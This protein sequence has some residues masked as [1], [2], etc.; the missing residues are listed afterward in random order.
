MFSLQK[1][2]LII[3]LFILNFSFS[4]AYSDIFYN[5]QSVYIDIGN[6]SI[7]STL[8][9]SIVIDN[10]GI[11]NGNI[12]IDYGNGLIVSTTIFNSNIVSTNNGNILDF[13]SNSLSTVNYNNSNIV[14]SNITNALLQDIQNY[15]SQV[16]N[17]ASESILILS[18]MSLQFSNQ[19]GSNTNEAICDVNVNNNLIAVSPMWCKV[20]ATTGSVALAT[21]AALGCAALASACAAAGGFTFGTVTFA[22]G[23][24]IAACT[25]GAIGSAPAAYSF[26]TTELWNGS[27]K[28]ISANCM[29]NTSC[30]ELEDSTCLSDLTEIEC[31][32]QGGN[33][34]VCSNSTCIVSASIP[35]LS[36]WSLILLALLMLIIGVVGIKSKSNELKPSYEQ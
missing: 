24:I 20:L 31:I 21:A 35:T 32:N 10:Q 18:I 15:G 25:A 17:Y 19:W 11:A 28:V 3:V 9:G 27:D 14:L 33:W 5:N 12:N 4:F 23:P 26:I 13:L 22:C 29:P 36:Q 7:P 2:L 30:C 1:K 16:E 34:E 6:I 8:N